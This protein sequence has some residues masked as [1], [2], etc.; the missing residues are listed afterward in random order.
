MSVNH[1]KTKVRHFRNQAV[2]KSMFQ[3]NCGE[4][5]IEYTDNY[6][7]R[8]L[9]LNEYFDYNVMAKYVAQSAT[10]ALGLLIL[11]FKQ[12][13]G[14]PFDVFKKL[15]DNTIWSIISYGVAIWGVKEY[16]MINT[17]QNKACRFFLGVGKYTPN[18]A[19][20]GDMGWTPSYIK[21]MNSV[22]S[23]MN[24]VPTKSHG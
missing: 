16:A 22:L 9:I 21:Q 18:A 1:N 14:M 12:A 6:R 7:Y 4:S 3:F 13:G 10:S 24:S 19:V 20:N 15:Y 5:N 2:P 11:K 8:G 17:V 23:Q